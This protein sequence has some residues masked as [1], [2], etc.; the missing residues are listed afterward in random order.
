MSEYIDIRGLSFSYPSSSITLFE[1]LSLSFSEGWTVISGANGAGKTT[2]VKI[3]LHLL[4]PDAGTVSVRGEIAFCPQVFT[5]LSDDDWFTIYDGSA[6]M[7]KLKSRLALSDEMIENVEVLSGG[8]KKRLQLLASLSKRPDI[9]ILDEPT[10]HLDNESRSMICSVLRDFEGCGV[11]ITHDRTA[12][13]LLSERTLLFEHIVP[14]PVRVHDIPLTLENAAKELERRKKDG[15]NAYDALE[16]AS[17]SLSSVAARLGTQ[18]SSMQKKLSKAGLD[19]HDH[20]GKAKIDGARLTGKDRSLDDQRRRILSREQQIES[21]LDAMEKPL[22][23]KEGLSFSSGGYIPK[24]SFGPAGLFAGTYKLSVPSLVIEPGMHVA[25]KGRNGS[26]KTVLV[27]AIVEKF[28]ADGRSGNLLYIP[29]EY[30]EEEVQRIRKRVDALSDEERGMVLSDIYRLG[31][32]PSFLLDES[33]A[34]S[35]GE[36]KKLDFVLSR[37]EGRNIIIMDEPTNHL[38]IVSL[39]IFESMLK[40][41]DTSF[42]LLLVSHDELFTSATCSKSWHL[43]REGQEGI[44]KIY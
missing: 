7:G 20:S 3:I 26:G 38:D 42:S 21:K 9:L 16:S 22:L 11:V 23:R 34:P 29:Q 13:A 15:R 17:S 8:E 2:L 25:V 19:I 40:K 31:S 36:L 30:S 37:R 27:K 5:S 35:P 10:N 32:E 44:V 28:I 39:R 6:E 24:L 33:S 14:A 18:S 43:E 1:N 41:E 4:L 12:A